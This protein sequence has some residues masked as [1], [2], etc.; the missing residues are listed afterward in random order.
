MGIGK[1][2]ITPS[3]D[4]DEM[5]RTAE[6][7]HEIET[8]KQD[9]DKLLVEIREAKEALSKIRQDLQKAIKA[10]ND[11]AIMLRAAIGSSDNITNGI[12]NA[13]V[14]AERDTQFKATIISEH[15]AQLQQLIDKAI[16]SWEKA[17]ENHRAEQTRLITEH[18]SNMRK[19]LRRNEGVWYSDFWMKVL[20]IFVF[21]YSVVLGL[22]TYCAT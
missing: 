15:F 12:C 5:F 21:V 3:I 13:I 14:K 19:I 6:T 11:A 2:K 9:A 18:E 7:S 1:S 4:V 20:V 8:E 16:E 10:E 17:L 22:I